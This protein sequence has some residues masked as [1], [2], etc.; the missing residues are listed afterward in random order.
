VKPGEEVKRGQLL[1]LVGKTGRVTGP[2]LHF[3]AHIDRL[4][5]NPQALLALPFPGATSPPAIFL[6]PELPDGGVPDG[7]PSDAG[8]LPDAG[9]PFR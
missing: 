7:G 6:P 3:G 8:P 5:V 2:H 1:G 4:W 9:I